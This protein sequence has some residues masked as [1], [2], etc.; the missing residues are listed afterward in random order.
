MTLRTSIAAGLMVCVLF[1][2][3]DGSAYGAEAISTP[4]QGASGARQPEGDVSRPA[5]SVDL[6]ILL[7]DI[8]SVDVSTVTTAG[9]TSDRFEATGVVAAAGWPNLRSGLF[10]LGRV[11]V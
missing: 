10:A 11:L 1:A 7:R 2:T 3:L 5:E 8:P 9:P 4:P 6:G